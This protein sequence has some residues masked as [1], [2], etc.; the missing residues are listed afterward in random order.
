M[1]L[2]KHNWLT[3]GR[4]GNL[5]EITIKDEVGTKLDFF[6]TTSQDKKSV[7]KIAKI[8][9][10]KYGFDLKPEIKPEDSINNKKWFEKDIEW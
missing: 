5:I 7:K 2:K 4:K 8:I 3:Y 10:D 9:K 1:G 6:R